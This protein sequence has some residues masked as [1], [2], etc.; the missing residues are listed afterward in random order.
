MYVLFVGGKNFVLLQLHFP[1]F[2]LFLALSL[3]VSITAFS[4]SSKLFHRGRG[5][6]VRTH[7]LEPAAGA[8]QEKVAQIKVNILLVSH[9][10]F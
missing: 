6:K 8:T 9:L 5:K 1:I 10:A 3:S 7:F 4:Q 2:I